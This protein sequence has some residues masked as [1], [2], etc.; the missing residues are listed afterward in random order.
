MLMGAA[1]VLGAIWPRARGL[2]LV[3]GALFAV[4]STAVAAVPLAAPFGVPTLTQVAWLC[5]AVIAQLLA[6]IVVIR[7]FGPRGERPLLLAVLVV[8]GLHFVP[9]A[10]AFGP[11][12]ALLGIFCAVNAITASAIASYSLRLTW[13]VDGGLKI[14]MGALLWS[15]PWIGSL[16]DA[17]A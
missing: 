17:I 15:I 11:L 6:L 13:A 1:I 7:H 2:L 8:V 3:L 10:P 12:V 4:A 14:V 16:I 5:G 9:M